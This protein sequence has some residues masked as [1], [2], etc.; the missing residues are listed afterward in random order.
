MRVLLNI[1]HL[2]I[3]VHAP[4]HIHQTLY[5]LT[6]LNFPQLVPFF[7]MRTSISAS[8]SSSIYVRLPTH[9]STSIHRTITH[10]PSFSFSLPPNA[11][12]DG[13][14]LISK[15]ESTYARA[16]LHVSLGVWECVCVCV[17][18]GWSTSSCTTI[19]H[20]PMITNEY[21]HPTLLKEL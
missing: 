21:L 6:I 18:R 5:A 20:H 9:M 10:P 14:T 16:C 4:E 15:I 3:S 7:V 17:C 12:K 1:M 11:R 13:T 2:F 19:T 8:G